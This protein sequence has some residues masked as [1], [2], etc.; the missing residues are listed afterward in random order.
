MVIKFP[1]RSYSNLSLSSSSSS[2]WTDT[3][4]ILF[5]VLF[6][7]IFTVLLAAW[8]QDTHHKDQHHN[9]YKP[10]EAGM[11]DYNCRSLC[12]VK[13]TPQKVCSSD[14]V[15]L[16]R[17]TSETIISSTIKSYQVDTIKEFKKIK[18]NRKRVKN[19]K[20]NQVNQTEGVDWNQIPVSSSVNTQSFFLINSTFDC[21]LFFKPGKDYIISGKII[22]VKGNQ[23]SLLTPC[24]LM[25]NW[26]NL[27]LQEMFLYQNLV[28]NSICFK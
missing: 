25:A 23:V 24:D 28:K 26:S 19:A 1:S 15:R 10:I 7:G 20:Q 11:K 3:C 18:K 4:I 16:V 6:C 12:P 8:H 14:F 2:I 13:K 17:I 5:V 21:N 27:S 22:T 9:R